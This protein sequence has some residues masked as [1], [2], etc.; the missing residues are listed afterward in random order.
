[1]DSTVIIAI[2]AAA[3]TVV[4]GLLS[5]CISNSITKYRIE[6]LEKKVDKHNNLIERTFRIEGEIETLQH[7]VKLL[8]TKGE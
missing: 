4:S 3:G 1:M 8:R 2:I 5:A 6:Q 7:D